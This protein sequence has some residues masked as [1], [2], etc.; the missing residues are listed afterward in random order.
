MLPIGLSRALL[1]LRRRVSSDEL[2]RTTKRGGRG[3][4]V[5]LGGSF[6]PASEREARMDDPTRWCE[7]DASNGNAPYGAPGSQAGAPFFS[8]PLPSLLSLPTAPHRSAN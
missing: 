7:N 2:S 6:P 5:V 8:R 3:L 1:E 4:L